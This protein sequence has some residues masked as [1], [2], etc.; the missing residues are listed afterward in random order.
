MKI[1][2]YKLLITKGESGQTLVMLLFFMVIAI[3]ITSAAVVMVITNSLS[4]T[5]LQQGQIV[6]AV[7][8]SGA[9]NALMRLLRNPSYTGETLPVGSGNAVV[10]VTNSGSTYTIL[11]QGTVGNFLKKIQVT[12]AYTNNILTVNSWGEVF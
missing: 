9:E 3:T 1:T 2:G 7:A 5:K 8:E 6:Y 11:S 10:T 4:A 12:A